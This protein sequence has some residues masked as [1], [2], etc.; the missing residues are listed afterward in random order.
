VTL[1]STGQISHTSAGAAVSKRRGSGVH[2]HHTTFFL[3]RFPELC[4]RDP[5]PVYDFVFLGRIRSHHDDA[6][7]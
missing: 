3:K 7:S 5:N 6:R 4:G 1:I 2:H